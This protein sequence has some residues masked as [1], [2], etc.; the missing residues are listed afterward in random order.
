MGVEHV[1]SIGVDHVVLACRVVDDH[2]LV[3]SSFRDLSQLPRRCAHDVSRHYSLRLRSDQWSLAAEGCAF[4]VCLQG[5]V[6]SDCL[7]ASLN[8]A[9]ILPLPECRHP[10]PGD[11]VSVAEL[12]CGGFSGWSHVVSFLQTLQMPAEHSLA[13][14]VDPDCVIAYHKTF[15]GSLQLLGMS[16]QL[17]EHGD[18]PPS[19]VVES[20]VMEFDWVHL[21]GRS[22]LDLGLASPPCPPWSRASLNAPGLRRKDGVLTPASIALFAL[23]GCKVICIENV[24]GLFHHAHWRIVLEWLKMWHFELRWAKVLDLADVCTSET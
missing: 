2:H 19:L 7:D 20:D 14:D 18:L 17:D 24:S 21:A 16:L 3:Q 15:G 1:L 6:F 8:G 12:F 5:F 9:G 22:V 13:V 10:S 23:L 11:K 4:L